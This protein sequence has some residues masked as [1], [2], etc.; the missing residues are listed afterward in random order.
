M[1]NVDD[2]RDPPVLLVTIVCG[3]MQTGA[4][5]AISVAW[6]GIPQLTI[7]FECVPWENYKSLTF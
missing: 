6:L 3:Q 4:A 5:K 1:L 7:H 2:E